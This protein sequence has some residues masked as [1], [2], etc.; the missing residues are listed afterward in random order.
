MSGNSDPRGV[1][2]SLHFISEFSWTPSHP[3]RR[4]ASSRRLAF[5]H[6]CSSGFDWLKRLSERHRLRRAY[7]GNECKTGRKRNCLHGRDSA[8]LIPYSVLCRRA[9]KNS[10]PEIS[11][12]LTR[13]AFKTGISRH[14]G[15]ITF[16]KIY[17]WRD[18]TF[19]RYNRRS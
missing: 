9:V 4:R 15:S 5:A 2:I 3:A 19:L 7:W 11:R 12:L 8:N 14:D 17:I 1:I 6:C 13:A 10:S 16:W 18:I